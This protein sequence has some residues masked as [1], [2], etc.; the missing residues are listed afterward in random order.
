MKKGATNMEK[1][2]R[3]TFGKANTQPTADSV[4]ATPSASGTRRFQANLAD[5]LLSQE[6]R[7]KLGKIRQASSSNNHF[8]M[9]K[10]GN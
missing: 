7:E 8:E 6:Q 1:K 4:L 9:M 5:M 10:S 3:N 2:S